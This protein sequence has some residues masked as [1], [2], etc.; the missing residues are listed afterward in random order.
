MQCHLERVARAE[1]ISALRIKWGLLGGDVEVLPQRDLRVHIR[2]P[3]RKRA[4]AVLSQCQGLFV[5]GCRRSRK[6]EIADQNGAVSTE[7]RRRSDPRLCGV[8]I[9]ERA[10][11]GRHASSF[12]GLVDD[13]VVDEGAGLIELQ[14]RAEMG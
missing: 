8:V 2:K 9:R 14:C 7:V 3:A 4:C 1:C 11:R 6:E 5:C 13:V 12:V 10:V